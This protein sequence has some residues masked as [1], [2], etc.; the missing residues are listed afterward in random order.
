MGRSSSVYTGIW[1]LHSYNCELVRTAYTFQVVIEESPFP[2][3]LA[4]ILYTISARYNQ[5]FAIISNNS[6]LSNIQMCH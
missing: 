4:P 5:V 6:C 1:I 3:S 2:F